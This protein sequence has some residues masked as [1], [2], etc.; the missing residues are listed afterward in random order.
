MGTIEEN[1]VD[2]EEEY[3]SD[4]EDGGAEQA[5]NVTY[6]IVYKKCQRFLSL[7]QNMYDEDFETELQKVQQDNTYDTTCGENEHLP[8]E[9]VDADS[10]IRQS[11]DTKPLTMHK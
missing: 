8:G 9:D 2:D 10:V 4:S 6:I 3:Y 7:F 5:Y 11:L 1:R